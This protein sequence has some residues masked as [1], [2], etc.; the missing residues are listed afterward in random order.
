M[1][2]K[3]SAMIKE[4]VRSVKDV[5][6]RGEDPP[7]IFLTKKIPPRSIGPTSRSCQIWLLSSPREFKY[8]PVR[9]DCA[10]RYQSLRQSILPSDISQR[11]RQ[12]VKR[13]YLFLTS[14]IFWSSL[15]RP[16]CCDF[17]Y[18]TKGDYLTDFQLPSADT[19]LSGESS[20]SR[21]VVLSSKCWS[22]K[23]LLFVITIF[24]KMA[25]SLLST[26]PSQVVT[27][28]ML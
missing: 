12:P 11:F 7:S 13:P 6:E 1:S 4:T 8:Q 19:S 18:P 15:S 10:L 25:W 28:N 20:I 27:G 26:L 22:D 17:E 14:S 23:T 2:C 9:R 5:R 3:N 24:I 16:I 21:S